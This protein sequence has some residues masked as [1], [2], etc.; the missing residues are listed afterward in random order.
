M[1]VRDGQ[2][3]AETRFDPAHFGQGL[4]LGTVPILTRAIADHVCPT[5]V[6][7]RELAP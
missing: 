4:T 2:Q 6:T 5:V 3:L 1:E 7:L